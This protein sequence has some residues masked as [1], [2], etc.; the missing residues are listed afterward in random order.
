MITVEMTDDIRQYETK[1]LGPFTLRQTICVGL[2]AAIAIPI[3]LLLPFEDISNKL[4]VAFFIAMPF[5]LCG[6]IKPAGMHFEV[7]SMRILY[8]S[9]LTPK[10]RRVRA[11]NSYRKAYEKI[12][13]KEEQARLKKMP[14]AQRKRYLK[15]KK[16][17]TIVRS[18]K[19]KYRIY[20]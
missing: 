14:E 9:V 4:F 20:Q 13:K 16:N 7:F 18:S 12:L 17:N 6:W 10:K 15:N 3:A 19:K 2:G 5:I 11:Q 8:S 1:F